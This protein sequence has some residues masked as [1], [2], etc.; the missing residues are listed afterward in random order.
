VIVPSYVSEQQI[1]TALLD[2]ALAHH[3]ALFQGARSGCRKIR[4]SAG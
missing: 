1:M 3:A 4:Q 2:G